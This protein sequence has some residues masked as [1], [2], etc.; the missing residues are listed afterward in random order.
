MLYRINEK[1]SSALFEPANSELDIIYGQFNAP[2][3]MVVYSRYDCHFC[4]KFFLETFPQIQEQ[5]II[6]GKLK[7]VVKLVEF[8][9]DAAVENALKTA[10][11]IHKY[12]NF[13]SLD[14]L[15]LTAPE[16]IYAAEFQEITESFIQTDMQF[17]ECMVGGQATNYLNENRLEFQKLKLTGTPTFVING[18]IYKGYKPFAEFKK[19][20]EK[21]LKEVL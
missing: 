18:T 16:V 9:N 7:V 6:P 17:A 14:K 21:E 19:S 1:K 8:A 13:E 10:V 4:Q 12:G 11:C 15:L 20:I 3:T 5:F 2:L